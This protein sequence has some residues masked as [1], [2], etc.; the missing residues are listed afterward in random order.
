MTRGFCFKRQRP[1]KALHWRDRPSRWTTSRAGRLVRLSDI[2]IEA[3]YGWFLVWRE[4]LRG[5]R[6]DLEAFT[7]WLRHEAQNLAGASADV[8]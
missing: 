4:P 8:E 3:D 2:E 1:V 6:T 5:D 7:A